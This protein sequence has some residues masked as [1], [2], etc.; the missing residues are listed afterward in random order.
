MNGFRFV[1]GA[2]ICL[3]TLGTTVPQSKLLAADGPVVSRP[4]NTQ[5]A[6]AIPNI[7]LTEGSKLSGRVV[8]HTGKPLEGAQVTIKQNKKEVATAVTDKAGIYS[9]TNLKPGMYNIGSGNTDGMFRV[10]DDRTAPPSAKEHALI[11]MGENGARGQLGCCDP[12]LILLTAGVIAAVILS[13]ITL[14]KVDKLPTSP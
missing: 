14:D 1:K 4:A 3:A 7:V 8:D 13:A 9:F 5:R 6:T 10:W 12:T 11:I 2:A